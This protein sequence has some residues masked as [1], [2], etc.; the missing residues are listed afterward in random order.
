[1][2]M[3]KRRLY[4]WQNKQVRKRDMPRRE[5]LRPALLSGILLLAGIVL[6]GTVIIQ[7]GT[8]RTL[9][10]YATPAG[11]AL[12]EA[13]PI[14]TPTPTPLP[15][16]VSMQ[17]WAEASGQADMAVMD[18]EA[19]PAPEILIYHTHA[20]EA[21]LNTPEE[22]YEESGSW[23]TND[24]EKNVVAL[25]ELLAKRL[26]EKGFSVLHDTTNH[27]PPKLSTAYSRS[28]AA[29]KTY[30][31]QYPT[32]SV[33]IDLH[34]DAYGKQTDT[35]KDYLL[36]DGQETARLMFV[37]GTGKG[38]TGSG[39]DEMP[40][41]ESNLALAQE[42]T[43]RL[44]GV[45]AGLARE[46]RVKPGR[47]NQHVSSSCLLVEVGHNANTFSQAK[48]AVTYLADALSETLLG[49]QARPKVTSLSDWTP[50]T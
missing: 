23:R 21:Y 3:G 26:E 20:T 15:T 24:N 43:T 25:G 31:K 14:P 6:I 28:L 17:V 35:P 37:V 18:E 1:M 12:M 11:A 39:F 16:P 29:M 8:R 42:I 41:F 2:D 46:V 49:R 32:L 4:G 48:R 40:D 19:A 9:V 10:Y 27:E 34:R 45:K 36:I 44:N 30:Q 5:D 50:G 13:Q 47:Y 38:A 33:F 22:P 7:K